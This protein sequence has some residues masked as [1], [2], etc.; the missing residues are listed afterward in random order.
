MSRSVSYTLVKRLNVQ[1]CS[2]VRHTEEVKVD[3]YTLNGEKM[4]WRAATQPVGTALRIAPGFTARA[5]DVAPGLDAQLEANYSADEGRYLITKFELVAD[6]GEI[7]HR[8][9]RLVSIESIM[10]AAAPHCIAL[11]LDDGPPNMTAHELTTTEGRIL[12]AWLAAQVVARGN[13]DER[14]EAIELLYGIA[15]LSGNPPVQAIQQELGIPHRTAS[16]WTKKAR[17]EGRLA[18][19]SYIVGR[20][21]DG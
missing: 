14:M 19:M 15:A 3:V 20:Q 17:A 2:T 21:A 8:A 10:R 7:T 6:G 11:S 13:R 9:L 4:T 1:I 18:G 5:F 12:P 16:D